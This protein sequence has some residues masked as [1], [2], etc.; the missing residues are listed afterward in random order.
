M[1][2]TAAFT[3]GSAVLKGLAGLGFVTLRHIGKYD[4]TGHAARTFAVG[5]IRFK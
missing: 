5:G 3:L 1:R 2:L 4:S